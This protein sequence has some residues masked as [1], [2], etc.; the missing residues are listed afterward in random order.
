[1]KLA[2]VCVPVPTFPDIVT[3]AVAVAVDVPGAYRTVIVQLPPA[4]TTVPEA[5]VPP[6]IEKV[7]PA[8]PT[9]P[10]VGFAVSVSDRFAPV[11]LLTVIVPFFVV[12]LAGVDVNTGV[13]ALIVTAA[14]S[15]A[16]DVPFNVEVC[17]PAASVTDMVA[18][19]A[20]TGC[21]VSG[22]NC[23]A[24]RQVPPGARVTLGPKN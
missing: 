23:T 4:A 1:M 21:A 18:G 17:V 5:Q 8:K 9:L 22:L 3:F 24:T 2:L 13:G 16:S 15:K 19:L 10:I 7:P 12:V 11:G 20:P 6:V 14:V